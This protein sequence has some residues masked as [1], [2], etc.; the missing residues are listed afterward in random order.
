MWGLLRV[1]RL[2]AE[3]LSA[4]PTFPLCWLVEILCQLYLFCSAKWAS[5]PMLC[6]KLAA[7]SELHGLCKHFNHIALRW[8]GCRLT[9]H[10]SGRLR[11]RLI[12]SLDHSRQIPGVV[13]FMAVTSI[14]SPILC[15]PLV[16]T[17]NSP[18]PPSQ[19][20]I[21]RPAAH[22]LFIPL[23]PRPGQQAENPSNYFPDH[24]VLR[25]LTRHSS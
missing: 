7:L 20:Y 10:P 9:R 8:L 12:Q 16:G 1:M 21:L 4:N 2:E 19:P 5:W 17:S 25:G 11:R 6:Q 3:R 15:R 14:Q 24:F 22:P 13:E 18:K 23:R